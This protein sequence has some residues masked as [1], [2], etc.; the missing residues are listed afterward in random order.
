MW[1][2]TVQKVSAKAETNVHQAHKQP[3]LDGAA[4]FVIATLDRELFLD[5]DQIQGP[6]SL[7]EQTNPHHNSTRRNEP[8]SCSP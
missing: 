3:M 7:V 4:A 1:E 2:T 5:D 6:H 8:S